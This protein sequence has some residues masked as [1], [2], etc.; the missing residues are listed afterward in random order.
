LSNKICPSTVVFPLTKAAFT[1][2]E[3]A[4]SEVVATEVHFF[5]T[6]SSSTVC[7]SSSGNCG[8]ILFSLLVVITKEGGV[9]GV[10]SN[11]LLKAY[12]KTGAMFLM[13][14]SACKF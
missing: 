3:I 14:F 5:H 6:L 12:G 9:L 2:V 7:L 10:G 1:L 11:V 8:E 4:E 13:E